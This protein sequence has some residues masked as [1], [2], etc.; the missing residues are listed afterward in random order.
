[1]N[2][3]TNLKAIHNGSALYSATKSLFFNERRYEFESNSQLS[4]SITFI[5][6]NCFSMN[7]DT[8]LKAIHN[9]GKFFNY[10]GGTVF[11]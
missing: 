6:I 5:G 4:D 2:E 10:S 11:Q 3:D 9:G 8:N 1:M 7:E